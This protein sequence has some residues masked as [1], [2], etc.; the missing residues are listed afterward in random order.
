MKSLVYFTTHE[1]NESLFATTW[2]SMRYAEIISQPTTDTILLTKRQRFIK[3][4]ID[5]PELRK[6]CTRLLGVVAACQDEVLSHFEDIPLVNPAF[7]SSLLG[8]YFGKRS[9][10]QSQIKLLVDFV[11][12]SLEIV[13]P[14]I[15]LP[16]RIT[17]EALGLY[18]KYDMPQPTFSSVW[19]D[20]CQFLITEGKADYAKSIGI[21]GSFMW[22]LGLPPAISI[23]R[24]RN[25][26]IKYM[27]TTARAH[28]ELIVATKELAHILNKYDVDMNDLVTPLDKGFETTPDG[29]ELKKLLLS[30]T[31]N[32]NRIWTKITGRVY[33]AYDLLQEQTIK[34][35]IARLCR[36]I[37]EL[38]CY[39][40]LAH[41][42][43][44]CNQKPENHCCFAQYLTQSATPLIEMKNTWNTFVP[45]DSVVCNDITLGSK[46][47]KRFMIITGPN[48]GGKSTYMK[49]VFHNIVLAQT[50]GIAFA[51]ECTITPFGCLKTYANITDDIAEGDS[52]FKKSIKHAKELLDEITTAKNRGAF[53]FVLID[54]LFSGTSV[55]QVEQLSLRFMRQ[56][57][58]RTSCV[59]ISAT[60]YK[61]VLE[62][63]T[64]TNGI[65]KNYQ[66]G[67][68]TN[69]DGVFERYTYRIEPG[70]SPVK[71][72]MQ[73][74]VDNGLTLIE[75][76]I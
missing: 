17:I 43:V 25:A 59:G 72:A 23:T 18:K 57:L 11:G 19:V 65:V 69:H 54:E 73:V 15:M 62:L 38:D 46:D 36:A 37:G 63:E 76:I 6:E 26:M 61:S 47:N 1:N 13:Y 12:M 45:G 64:N 22:G 34:Q 2:G 56:L 8:P 68:V 75:T 51:N 21:F 74:A 39:V 50:F 33:T 53:S 16:F 49:S 29:K 10:I 52:T 35:E 60:H 44:A 24:Q 28:R 71:N 5:T 31:F 14:F 7:A 30:P 3:L 32:N 20:T 4:L 70:I 48:A 40:T 9:S 66:V 42:M 58:D 27:N 67:A 55:D 41:K